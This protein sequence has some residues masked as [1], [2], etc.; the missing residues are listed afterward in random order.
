MKK[1][2][3]AAALLMLSP[4]YAS[5]T[6]ANAMNATDRAAG[7]Y[8]NL[9]SEPRHYVAEHFTTASASISGL[10]D[11][12][13]VTSGRVESEP[14]RGAT[15]TNSIKI[16]NA[17]GQIVAGSMLTDA[18]SEPTHRSTEHFTATATATGPAEAAH[19][20]GGPE[21]TRIIGLTTT[22][23]QAEQR[24]VTVG[25][26]ESEPVHI[27]TKDNANMTAT[28]TAT[29]TGQVA[30][31]ATMTNPAPTS[32]YGLNAINVGHVTATAAAHEAGRSPTLPA[33]K[34]KTG[35]T[36]SVSTEPKSTMLLIC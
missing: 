2:M 7:V 30:A 8:A 35:S 13:N 5:T 1:M 18:E 25:R 3:I 29:A 14:A 16:A 23:G 15:M 36:S 4:C 24:G 20:I 28:A 22:S 32:L 6:P 9:E 19:I 31:G 17:N 34:S 21:P 10:A 27:A 12:L 33:N 26:V 11:L